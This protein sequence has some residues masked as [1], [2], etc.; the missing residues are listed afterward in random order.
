MPRLFLFLANRHLFQA[1]PFWRAFFHEQRPL[2]PSPQLRASGPSPKTPATAGVRKAPQLGIVGPHSL[3]VLDA[4]AVGHFLSGAL[5]RIVFSPLGRSPLA[6]HAGYAASCVS[7]LL[8]LRGLLVQPPRNSRCNNCS[9]RWSRRCRSHFGK[10]DA[11]EPL[12]S[13]QRSPQLRGPLPT[14]A[15]SMNSN[16]PQNWR[17]AFRPPTVATGTSH[18]AIGPDLTGWTETNE[19]DAE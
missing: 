13:R 5:P 12:V 16:S 2:R 6:F 11:P 19:S 18:C 3:Q 4:T 9:S 8:E 1:R 7:G 14:A 10:K 15:K 17:V